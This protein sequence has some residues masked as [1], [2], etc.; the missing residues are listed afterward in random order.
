MGYPTERTGGLS[1]RRLLI[2]GT[3]ALGT[4]AIATTALGTADGQEAGD[5][6]GTDQPSGGTLR[7]AIADRPESLD[8]L[9]DDGPTD[10]LAQ[11]VFGGLYTY[12]AS[13]GLVPFLAA[14]EPQIADERREYV[15]E[16]REN[17]RFQN[18]EP[19]TAA[20]VR[21]SIRQARDRDSSDSQLATVL[22]SV[23]VVDYRTVRIRL[24]E[25]Y[26]PF[27]HL[28]TGYVVPEAA[29]EEDTEEF[30]RQPIGS[31]PFR[32]S[33]RLPGE[34]L[35]L[36]R[37]ADY[38]AEPG[39]RLEVA[40]FTT[41]EMPTAR[42]NALA[43]GAADVAKT[44]PPQLYPDLVERSDTQIVDTPR[45]DYV[46]LAFNCRAGPTADPA[47]RRG[48]DACISMDQFVTEFVGPAGQR[49]VSPIPPPLAADWE[50]PV[51]QWRRI[52]HGRDI[53]AAREHF[54]SAGVPD[55]WTPAIL[56]PDEE[57]YEQLALAVANGLSEA[58]YR[59]S[60]EPLAPDA[61]RERRVTGDPEDYDMYV[62]RWTAIPD[63]D[64]FTY[65][66]FA[67]EAEGETNGTYY[68]VESV[69][70]KLE[71]ARRAIRKPE[72]RGLYADAI[73]TIIEDRAHLPA[74]VTRYSFAVSDRVHDFSA[75][76]VTAFQLVSGYNNV[77]VDG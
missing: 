48:I 66:L 71:T 55:G 21:Y 29:R 56:V 44:V 23:E 28:L 10:A 2:R 65:P 39:P 5:Q 43:S 46:H 72:R 17:A 41:I 77:S 53:E 34:S 62:D 25:A 63:P 42:I 58:G 12:D 9:A 4:A 26:A 7:M 30:R 36:E 20:D 13:T 11:L 27:V 60:I 45:M 33:E 15:V 38:W 73:T 40:K 76:P 61:F 22:D 51:E 70:E 68:R 59:A 50:F 16:L 32:V 52:T 1:R 24:S 64:A 57:V 67:T 47:V 75:H 31:G 6:E 69:Q 3:G 18:D 74:F 19:V 54:E 8:P 35:R 49:T 37:W 14:G